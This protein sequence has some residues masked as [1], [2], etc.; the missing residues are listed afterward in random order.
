MSPVR[1]VH[2]H[3]F[4][5]VVLGSAVPVV[6]GF[7]ASDRPTACDPL[8]S[9]LDSLAAG[10]HRI[11]VARVDVDQAPLTSA[12]YGASTVPS[13]VV[14]DGG[15]MALALPG[16]PSLELVLHMLGPMVDRPAPAESS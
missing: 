3:D 4:S 14:F 13:V 10:G 12:A 1:S 8:V 6:V 7:C 16:V 9:V 2:D 5:D 15:A 11:G